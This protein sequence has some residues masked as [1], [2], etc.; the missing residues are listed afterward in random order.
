[1]ILATMTTKGQLTVP[2]EVRDELGL[3]AG[4][5]VSFARN[6]DGTYTLARGGGSVMALAGCLSPGGAATSHA[7]TSLAAMERAISDGAIAGAMLG[8]DSSPS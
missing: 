6:A 7:T 3:T 2:K 8:G 1:M 4:M 5:A